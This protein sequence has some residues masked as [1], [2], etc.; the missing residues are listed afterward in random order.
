MPKGFFTQ[1]VSILLDRFASLDDIETVLADFDVCARRDVTETWEFFAPNVTVAFR[2][3]ANGYVAIDAVKATWPDHMGD[4][5]SETNLFGAWSMGYFGPFAYPGALERAALQCWHWEDAKT[6]PARHKAFVRIR[7]SYAFGTDADAPVMPDDY[8]PLPELEFVTKLAS[9]LLK[10]PGALCYFNPNGEVVRDQD[11]LRDSLNFHWE[12]QLPPFDV[13]SNVRLVNV[14]EA[15]SMMD[16]VGNAQLDIPDSEACFHTESYDCGEIDNFLRNVS[17]Y[18]LNHGEVLN[19]GD[20]M[21]GP[22]DI[23]WQARHLADSMWS[24]PRRV[25]RWFPMDKR[26]V[27]REIFN[28]ESAG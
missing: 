28:A 13:W 24:P 2:P 22:G 7:S 10:L 15:W 16:T 5:Q 20:T 8:E 26:K 1:G 14:D 12:N 6:M 25:L 27:P 21:D 4:P 18:Q 19:D 9:A 23:P 3:E 11:G 17:L